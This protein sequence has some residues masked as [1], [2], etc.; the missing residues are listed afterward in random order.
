MDW[1]PALFTNQAILIVPN[2][3]VGWLGLLLMLLAVIWL[4][5]SWWEQP[6]ETL[7]KYWGL[8]VLLIILTPVA[9]TIMGVRLD[10]DAP[11]LPGVPADAGAPTIV[12]FTALP[13]V[14]AAG[15]LGPLP[16]LVL[17]FLAGTLNAY[18]NTHNPATIFETALLALAF[19]AAVRQRYRTLF[20][21]LLRHPFVAAF[22]LAIAFIPV[23]ILST[24]FSVNGSSAVRL[25]Y[26][27]TQIWPFVLARASELLIAGTIAEIMVWLGARGWGRKG[28]LIPAPAEVSLQTRFVYG[29][30]PLV[31]IL[32]LVLAVGGWFVAGNAARRTVSERMSSAARV[33]ANSFPY[34]I[35]T[36]QSLIL[37][38]AEPELLD[39]PVETRDNFLIERMRS[40]PYFHQLAVFDL[41]GNFLYGYPQ[42]DSD[43]VRLTKEERAAIE[44]AGRGIAVQTYT[45]TAREGETSAQIV[46]I[47]AIPAATGQTGG[48]LFGWSDLT[49]TPFTQP[50]LRA[51]EGLD[52]LEGSTYVLDENQR[53][54]Y[55]IRDLAETKYKNALPAAEKLVDQTSSTGTRQYT[56]VQPVVGRPW[57]VVV[58]IPAERAQDLALEIAVPLLVTLMVISIVAFILLR[59]GLR[60]VTTTVRL[61]SAQAARIS[62]GDLDRPVHVQGADE[63]ARLAEAFEQMRRSLKARL[64]ELNRLLIVSQGVAANLEIHGAVR[65]ILTASLIENSSMSRVV[66]THEVTL[67]LRQEVPVSIGAGPSSDLFAYLDGQIYEMMRFQDLMTIPNVARMRRLNIPAGKP[68]PGA[69]LAIAIKHES[70]YFGAF[71]IAYD[72]PHNFIEEEIRFLSTLCGEIALAAAS[73]RLYATA[74]VGRQRLEGVL[75]SSPDPV[76][77]IDERNRLLL[78]NNAA[79]HTRGLVI[80]MTVGKPIQEM[81][82]IPDLVNQIIGPLDGHASTQEIHL[83]NGKVFYSSVAEVAVEGRSVGRICLL[84]DITH[85]K[86]LDQMKTD[87]VATVSHDL[88]SPLTL[89]RGYA[90]MMQMVGELNEQQKGY[91][92]KILGGIESM[93]RLVN[94]LLDLG[95]IEAGVGLQIERI[96]AT[97]VVE[98]AVNSLQLQATQKDIKL[99]IEAP[100]EGSGAVIEADRA[101]LQQALYNLVENAIKYTSSN[102]TVRV[103]IEPRHATVLFQVIDN[104]MGI[105]PIDLPRLFEKFYRS[106]RREAYQQ[107]GSGLG[108]AIV[109]SITDRHQGR[110]WVDSTLGKGSTFSLE[111]PLR[112]VGQGGQPRYPS[113]QVHGQVHGQTSK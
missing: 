105:A 96:P 17:G 5:W 92:K 3:W 103:K 16:A 19:G 36:G 52:D 97:Q 11:P 22:L 28:S 56:Y 6:A 44:L 62:V 43:A 18:T 82:A 76:M 106:G 72:Q 41:A 67:D 59:F 35:E 98:D 23:Y 33:V 80:G 58:S 20:Y 30:L 87:F 108:L 47:S 100:V 57:S 85:F 101:L 53:I 49:S 50:A 34:F 89:V 65:P 39:A 74:E 31:V 37:S 26:A 42:N 70:R 24:I 21:R 78:M 8:F 79:L 91:V 102:G 90:T 1:I 73:A 109:K 66:L 95:R 12:L 61:L 104:G 4:A 25:D 99:T 84:R 71:W 75:H 60:A 55:P 10:W 107:R 112:Q 77:V 48:V 29:T 64:D 51:L 38:M 113:G 2:H 68:S 83:S 94:N 111:L 14:L 110:V 9:A 54:L 15:F 93:N 81:I 88:R 63:V 69:L 7:A 32:F 13:W 46:F 27:F 40:V 86:E 45:G